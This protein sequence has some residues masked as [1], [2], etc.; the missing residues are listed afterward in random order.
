MWK[1]SPNSD[2]WQSLWSVLGESRV[3]LR[4]Y[5]VKA[6]AVEDEQVWK[7]YRPNTFQVV[8]NACADV[9]ANLGALAGAL[10]EDKVNQVLQQLSVVT[11]LQ[12]RC[13]ALLL[14]IL[15]DRPPH[16]RCDVS[17]QL[18]AQVARM[19]SRH[20]LVSPS[21]PFCLDCGWGPRGAKRAA[22]F[23][24]A[25]TGPIAVNGLSIAMS[26]VRVGGVAVHVSHRLWSHRGFHICVKCGYTGSVCIRELAQQCG[27]ELSTRSSNLTRVTVRGLVP[28][29][30]K[31]W[32]QP[33]PPPSPFMVSL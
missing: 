18:P 32:P 31:G 21:V 30:L 11:L 1:G 7:A 20:V 28:Y 25:C 19:S 5:W 15:G 33:P 4:L 6:H 16:S 9:L 8:G 13:L 3:T 24:Q 12:R 22:W 2:L 23:K 29:G 10:P 14:P 17:W 26:V 27:G